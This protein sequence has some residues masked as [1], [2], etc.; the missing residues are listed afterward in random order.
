LI[1]LNSLSHLWWR[2]LPKEHLGADL[3]AG[4]LVTVLVLP[5]SLAY[6]M[7]AG[8][9]PQV[10]LYASILPVIAYALVGSSM[11]Q[12]VGPVAITAIMTFSVLTPL[13]APG[14]PLYIALA[15]GLALLSGLLLLAFGMLRLGFLANLLSRP[16]VSGFIAGS[17]LLILLSQIS[18]LLGVPVHASS[19]WEQLLLTLKQLPHANPTTL[20]L[21][22]VG[23]GV[24][25]LRALLA[26]V[27]IQKGVP[28]SR[29]D[30]V[31]RL[32]PL[33]LVVVATLLVVALDLDHQYGVAVVGPV[34]NGLPE[35]TLRLPGV[36]ELGLLALPALVLAFI[37][38]VQNI[39]MAQALAMK[40]HERVDA[41]QELIGL[42]LSNIVAAFFGGM[43]VGGGLSRS[44]V[45]VAAGAQ[46]P[47]SSIVSAL[48]MLGIVLLG[49]NWFSR[50]PLAILAASIVVAAVSM[51]DV[52]ELRRAWAY[53]RADAL[54]FVSTALGVLVLGLQMG[55]ALGIG[56]SLATLLYRASTPHIAVVGRIVNT[57][58]FRNLERHGVE[59][60]PG[61]LF[62]RI[63]ESL[64]FG[65]LNAIESRLMG[66]IAKLPSVRDVVLI[67]S[68]VNRVDLTALEALTEIQLSL[69]ARGI[70]LH[71]AEVKGPVQDRMLKTPLWT[72][73]LGRVHLSANAAFEHLKS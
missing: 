61:A 47:L 20:M 52:A 70:E 66:E 49:T 4:L 38:T 43:P 67:M 50:I 40:R 32:V 69:R 71:L 48:F 72:N 59:T 27:L 8:L 31:S 13:A 12:A 54:A 68:A 21:S 58:H 29:A 65:N 15:A 33:L 9:P 41:N 62:L 35:L 5:Q 2:R 46:T 16:V 30:M 14:S 18:L 44:A 28:H 19:S 63:D 7:L 64:F 26:R 73:L 24:L 36:S 45:N 34:S 39:T 55:I 37:G 10:G 6:A 42:G 23:L 1:T 57:E 22:G 25:L 11:T 56:L 53:D 51:I 17:A 60:L 3:F